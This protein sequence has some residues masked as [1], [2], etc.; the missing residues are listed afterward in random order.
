MGIRTLRCRT[1]TTLSVLLPT[2]LRRVPG[3]APGAS[4]PRVTVESAS[5]ASPRDLARAAQG[6]GATT[7]TQATARP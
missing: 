4:T 5:L 3:Y 2:R 1:A 6:A 7:D